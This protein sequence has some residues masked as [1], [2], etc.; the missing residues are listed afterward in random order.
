MRSFR[1]FL[2][3]TGGLG[4][5]FAGG[6]QYSGHFN[7]PDIRNIHK[8]GELPIQGVQS[9][10]QATDLHLQN[11]RYGQYKDLYIMADTLEKFKALAENIMSAI[12]YRKTFGA[13]QRPSEANYMTAWYD[14]ATHII[15]GIKQNE[16]TGGT[17]P[18]IRNEEISRA[19]APDMQILIADPRM[20]QGSGVL[21]LNVETLRTKMKELGEQLHSLERTHQAWSHLAGVADRG[22]D[23]VTQQMLTPRANIQRFNHL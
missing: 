14:P 13:P 10:Q 19:Q 5:P 4:R 2:E 12:D 11:K 17:Y 23:A 8:P 7:L 16:V 6:T 21:A 20:P 1:Q 22:I 3:S 9:L 15:H 18:R